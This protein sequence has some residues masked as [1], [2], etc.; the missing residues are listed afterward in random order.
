MPRGPWAAR[1]HPFER[2]AHRTMVAPA[3]G[4]ATLVALLDPV[5]NGRILCER[6]G[7][8]D[9]ARLLLHSTAL[10]AQHDEI[11]A[12]RVF[13]ARC[14]EASPRVGGAVRA[15]LDSRV[16]RVA[17]AEVGVCVQ[18]R[19]GRH[20]EGLKGRNVLVAFLVRWRVCVTSVS[21]PIARK[22][23][24][25]TEIAKE[26]HGRRTRLAALDADDPLV[27]HRADQ[28]AALRAGLEPKMVVVRADCV[29]VRATLVFKAEDRSD[30]GLTL[31]VSW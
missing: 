2:G 15:A 12:G 25:L 16:V 22:V 21:V 27:H 11:D 4:P 26:D 18:E 24:V 28:E 17:A 6:P 23:G 31:R 29:H 1:L 30:S 19:E 20:G 7:R 8:S 9:G 10:R 5:V 3:A 13:F 14:P